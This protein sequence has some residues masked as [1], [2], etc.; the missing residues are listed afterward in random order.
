MASD[1]KLVENR[2]HSLGKTA[3]QVGARD[4]SPADWRNRY[5]SDTQKCGSQATMA[6]N[7]IFEQDITY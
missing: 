4:L 1:A 7:L 3:L 6:H 2:P 5:A